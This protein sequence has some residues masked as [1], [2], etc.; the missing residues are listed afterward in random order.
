MNNT[1]DL[2]DLIF[3]GKTSDI[4]APQIYRLALRWTLKYFDSR[5]DQLLIG[6]AM[7]DDV[8][9]MENDVSTLLKQVEEQCNKIDLLNSQ[10][11]KQ[12]E[13]IDVLEARV[14]M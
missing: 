11:A 10:V 6:L 12:G 8:T 9:D 2:A 14:A 3:T 5:F 4:P 1:S 13:I 7:K